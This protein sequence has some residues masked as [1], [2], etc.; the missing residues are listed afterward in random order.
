MNARKAKLGRSSAFAVVVA[1]CAGLLVLEGLS[2]TGRFGQ[3]LPS[4][5]W[6][7]LSADAESTGYGVSSPH[8]SAHYGS[9]V[10]TDAGGEFAAT[11]HLVDVIELAKPAVVSVTAKYLDQFDGAQAGNLCSPGSEAQRIDPSAKCRVLMASHGAGFLISAD[12]YVVT[13]HHVVEVS[14]TA[15]VMTSEGTAY[16]AAVIASDS[17]SD[18]ALLKIDGRSDFPF[19]RLTDRPPRVGQRVF[20]VGNPFG[21]EGSVTAGIISGLERHVSAE[22]DSDDD[23]I[24]IDA[25]INR[26]NSGGPT[27]DLEGNVVGVNTLIFSTSG[28]SAGVGLAVPAQK[29]RRVVA[30]LKSGHAVNRGWLGIRS[31]AVTPA[32]AEALGLNEARGALVDDASGPAARAGIVSGDVI[33]SVDAEQIKDNFDLSR[34]V[35]AL[36]PGTTVHVGVVRDGIQTTIAAVLDETPPAPTKT[37]TAI[38]WPPV[39]SGAIDLGLTLAPVAAS[40]ESDKTEK[41]GVVILAVKPDGRGA[42]LGITPGDVILE[43]NGKPV[44]TPHG[45]QSALQHEYNAGRSAALMRVKSHHM[46]WFIAVPFDPT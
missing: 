17:R 4:A 14:H 33:S 11:D 20:A 45:V 42:D 28:A 40:R 5:E 35:E 44:Q 29:V 18:L 9:R 30:Q 24:Q 10:G 43:V 13:N 27:F 16:K 25:P 38:E 12:G 34:R 36:A 3:M 39:L 46:T 19:V 23:F 15:E 32:I 31:Q 22:V 41:N 21:F 26:G 37:A 2:S 1:G 7:H 8:M 6:S